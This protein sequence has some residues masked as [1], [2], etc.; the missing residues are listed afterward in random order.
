M[1]GEPQEME[2]MF[3]ERIETGPEDRA[4]MLYEVC[5][6]AASK[7][8]TLDTE[9]PGDFLCLEIPN[10]SADAPLKGEPK[11]RTLVQ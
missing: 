9:E 4:S 3:E 6:T 5:P 11:G 2:G 1:L 8:G 10:N 7:L